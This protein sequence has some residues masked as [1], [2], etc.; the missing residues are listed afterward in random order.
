MRVEKSI[1]V[2]AACDEVWD[3]VTDP[4]FLGRLSGITRWDVQ[5]R[6]QR[7]QGARYQMRM[8]V[9]SA[10]VGSL[11]E[12]VEWDPPGDMAWTSLTGVD[13]RGRWRLREQEDGTTK[14][15]FRLSYQAP[16]GLLGTI[17]DRVAAPIVRRHLE[18]SLEMLKQELEGTE[19]MARSDDSPG[20]VGRARSGL[21]V[22]D[23][24]L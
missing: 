9:G 14:V 10:Q 19:D 8:S 2:D 12:V 13:Q 24:A 22:G 18:A 23:L 1:K 6:K 20:L 17:S 3:R 15:T 21:G 5:G 4:E 7:G 16:G 11:V